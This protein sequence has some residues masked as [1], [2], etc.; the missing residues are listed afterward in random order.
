MTTLPTPDGRDGD[1]RS[2]WRLA[3]GRRLYAGEGAVLV[4]E[5]A[6]WAAPDDVESDG[7]AYVAA[8]RWAR[9]NTQ[10]HVGS[11]PA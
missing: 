5:T 10:T 3:D 4:P 8:A 2:W 6:D 1:G 11:S 9:S 7:L